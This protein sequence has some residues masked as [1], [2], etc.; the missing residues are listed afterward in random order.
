MIINKKGRYRLLQDRTM[1]GPIS[2]E[3]YPAGFEFE[4]TQIDSEHHKVIGPD[5]P[6]WQYWDMPVEEISNVVLCDSEPA[7]YRRSVN[8]CSFCGGSGECPDC[9][10]VDL[11]DSFVEFHCSTC[12]DTGECPKCQD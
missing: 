4:V 7:P 12:R 2:I 3:T 5:L 8:K 10:N 11:P 6:D 9:S 1:R